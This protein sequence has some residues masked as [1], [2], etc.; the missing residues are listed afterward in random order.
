MPTLDEL[1]SAHANALNNGNDQDAAI[2]QKAISEM[3]PYA[4]DL[5]FAIF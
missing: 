4:L 1:K 2:L 5:K 3:Q